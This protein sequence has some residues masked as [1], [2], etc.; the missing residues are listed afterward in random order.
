MANKIKNLRQESIYLECLLLGGNPFLFLLGADTILLHWS[1]EGTLL[2]S[3]LEATVTHLT[4]GIDEVEVDLLKSRSLHLVHKRLE[5]KKIYIYVR[6]FQL[7]YSR[8]IIRPF[9][10]PDKQH[11]KDIPKLLNSVYLCDLNG[12]NPWIS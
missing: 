10:V 3:G 12:K 4:G 5:E 1:H 6:G 9:L 2:S 7:F 11:K 8:I